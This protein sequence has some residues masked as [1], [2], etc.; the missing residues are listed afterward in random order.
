MRC[1][2]TCYHLIFSA[3]DSFD[4]SYQSGLQ[5]RYDGE[6]EQIP[7]GMFKSTCHINIRWFPFDTQECKLKFGSWT[8][9]GTKI[10]LR[11]LG[12]IQEGYQGEFQP[13]GEWDLLGELSYLKW[14]LYQYR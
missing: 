10:D 9:D 6:A 12:G 11:F 4:A 1:T 8:Y 2:L 14:L 3:S 13:N 7:P 5:I